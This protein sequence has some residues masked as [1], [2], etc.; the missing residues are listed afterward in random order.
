MRD[1]ALIVL[2]FGLILYLIWGVGRF[3]G[4][5]DEELRI[6]NN[7][8]FGTTVLAIAFLFIHGLVFGFPATI[9]PWVLP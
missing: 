4:W 2:A 6:W 9:P 3:C 1:A 5:P 8:A 7:A